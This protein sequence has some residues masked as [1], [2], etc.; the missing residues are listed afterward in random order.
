MSY[1]L[2]AMRKALAEK[3]GG[4][5]DS[6]EFVPPKT[7]PNQEL[8]FRF[9]IL[10]PL[11]AG[12][13]TVDGVASRDMDVYFV[14][15]GAH[16]H[17]KKPYSCPRIH[18]N[19]Q[20]DQCDY[21]FEM[22]AEVQGDGQEAKKAKSAIAKN[23]LP[24]Q[25][26]AIN[27]Y[28]P[29]DPTNP[30]ELRGRIMWMNASQTITN[31]CEACMMADDG[32]DELKPRA[33]G[34]FFDEMNAYLFQLVIKEKGGYNNYESS[35]F[36]PTVRR[37]IVGIKDGEKIVP[38]VAKI[39]QVLDKR[40]DLYTKFAPPDATKI[41]SILQILINKK[42][43]P[44]GDGF[45]ADETKGQPKPGVIVGN[46][47]AG[48]SGEAVTKKTVAAQPPKTAAKAAPKKEPVAAV[49]EPVNEVAAVAT[50]SE[51]STED[52]PELAAL[53]NELNEPA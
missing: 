8:N 44:S 18:N 28:F 34:V 5:R 50:S 3:K 43:G 15:N 42:T 10:P 27:I 37:P 1:D 7:K 16:W 45:D 11:K 41:T 4:Q 53:M 23:Y 24:P 12:D 31:L 39:K 19:E 48:E 49:K 25:K 46:D 6:N 29:N 52:D 20:C 14:Q 21:G 40:H 17:N 33:F 35:Q 26:F 13:K 22:M 2:A 36:L 51:I 38:D 9:Y 30:E 32:G 47:L